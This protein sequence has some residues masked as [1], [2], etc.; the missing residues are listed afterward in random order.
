VEQPAEN[1]RF[2][3]TA[4]SD[5]SPAEFGGNPENVDTNVIVTVQFDT[6]TE[7]QRTVD[8]TISSGTSSG[9]NFLDTFEGDVASN[10]SIVSRTPSSFGSQIYNVA[11]LQNTGSC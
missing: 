5:L 9:S 10:V 3:F 7:N 2:I 8:I 11:G 1:W 6:L 4:Y